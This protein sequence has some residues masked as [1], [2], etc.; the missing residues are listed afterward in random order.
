MPA[1]KRNDRALVPAA[2]AQV[3][4]TRFQQLVDQLGFSRMLVRIADIIGPDWPTDPKTVED[5]RAT[6]RAGQP[7]GTITLR[8]LPSMGKYAILDGFHRV[9][10]LVL[11]NVLAYYADVVTCTDDEAVELRIRASL[12]K[13]QDV[14]HGRAIA[15]LR[16][17]FVE[18]LIRIRSE[19]IYE[20]AID[21]QG[22]EVAVVRR[23]P[24][25]DDP[26]MALLAV[27]HHLETRP[28]G[29]RLDWERLVEDWLADTARK[30]DRDTEW[31]RTEVL[32][33]GILT[34][35]IRDRRDSASIAK[36][37]NGIPDLGMRMAVVER[38]RSER[39]VFTHYMLERALAY[40][41]IGP[42]QYPFLAKH[43]PTQMRQLLARNSLRDLEKRFIESQNAWTKS[44]QAPE[45]VQPALDEDGGEVALI[46]TATGPGVVDY[47]DPYRPIHFSIE[48]LMQLIDQYAA[49]GKS[50]RH[51]TVQDDF[52]SLRDKLDGYVES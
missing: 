37:L 22:R 7:I 15:A 18:M 17:T 29:E 33:V 8:L 3:A 25:P 42:R 21:E 34:G 11:E 9:Q 41:G 51:G 32:N 26:T 46:D 14:L 30:F 19:T 43:N 49:Q 35:G 28:E 2:D 13:T 27:I 40:V 31:L 16:E 52:R 1:K 23:E 36:L 48:R 12:R 5:F 45:G 24:L 20:P 47:D 38:L 50:F 10:A 39:A 4:D 44:H 6:I